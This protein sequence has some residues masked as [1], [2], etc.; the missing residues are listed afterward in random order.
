MS[1]SH[2]ERRRGAA[3][4]PR[5]VDRR[6]WLASAGALVGA[7]GCQGGS[8]T[9]GE[10]LAADKQSS[11]GVAPLSALEKRSVGFQLAHEQFT[12]PELVELGVMAE[13]AGFDVVT[14]SD[15]FQPW[16][17]NEGHAGFAWVTLA[18]V[19]QRT[20]R[21]WLGTTVTCPTFRY[22]PAVV[23]QGVA[24]LAALHPGRIF[25]GVGSGEALNEQAATGE[26]PKWSERSEKLVEATAIIR[27]LW[28][29]AKTEAAGKHY[30]VDA[31]LYDPPPQTIPLLMAA[32]GPK[33]MRRAGQ[34]ADGLITDPKTWKQHRGEFDGGWNE[35]GKKRSPRPVFIEH[36]V[37]V[38]GESDARAAA[39]LWRFGPK[40][41]KP[42]VNIGD[43]ARIEELAKTE[44]PLEE[45]YK[46]WVVST[47]PAVHA[48]AI[49]DLFESGATEVNVHSGQA[50]QRRV[51]SFY[52]QEVLP[53]V[54]RVLTQ[55]GAMH[56]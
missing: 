48:N 32:N 45:V 4:S 56:G 2:Y 8:H 39:D 40:A 3:R 31:R 27:R 23:A 9:S 16:Q 5:V 11:A 49:I 14:A 7:V 37:V 20:K 52:G 17:A 34:H 43:P 15:H 42:Y 18:A 38:G 35:A 47:D 1:Q 10:G 6:T 25:L 29:G 26:W 33:A 46:D 55:R 41:W 53:R 13:G 12:M 44:I 50:D 22:H 30:V 21:V 19:G 54:R 24:T 36:Y 51:I 28:S